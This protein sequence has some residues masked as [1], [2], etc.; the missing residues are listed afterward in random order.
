MPRVRFAVQAHP[1]RAA[2]ASE[3]AE[4]LNGRVIFDPDPGSRQRSPWR[5]YRRCI[6][7]F[8][9]EA[10]HLVIVQDDVRLCAGFPDAARAAIAARPDHL[11]A[12]FVGG[13]PSDH[14]RAVVEACERDLPWARLEA[15]RWCPAIALGW[16]RRLAVDLLA[17]VD[18]QQWPREFTADDEIIGRY[19]AG[20]GVVPLATVPSLVEHPDTAPSLIGLR[21]RGGRDYARVAACMIP[22]DCDATAIDWTPGPT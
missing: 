4:A 12:F 2:D 3:L 5:T 20:R 10:S 13:E 8:P 9:P 21:H 1:D 22:D 16:P 11:I 6:E 18:V 19:V 7:L 17:F 14:A 15:S